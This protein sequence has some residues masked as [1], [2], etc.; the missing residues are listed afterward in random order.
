MN[1]SNIFLTLLIGILFASCTQEKTIKE[2]MT[3]SW[4]TTYL[5]IEMPTY[6]KSDSTFVFEDKFLNNPPKRAQSTY[7]SDGTFSAWF[8][9]IAGEKKDES[10]GKWHVKNDSLVV[11]FFYGGRDIKVLYGIEKT[12]EGFKGV[13]RYDWDNDGGFDDV[14]IMKTKRIKNK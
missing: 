10:T 7:N 11:E 8:V 5:K 3:D 2:Y 9:N 6:Q 14:L 4:E 12:S 1:F 13:S